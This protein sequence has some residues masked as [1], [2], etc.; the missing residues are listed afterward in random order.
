MSTKKRKLGFAIGSAF[1]ALGSL[2]TVLFCTSWYLM[3][4]FHETF[5]YQKYNVK[6]ISI[7]L[8]SST[9]GESDQAVQVELVSSQHSPVVITAHTRCGLGEVGK[10]LTLL[11]NENS[12]KVLGFQEELLD[13]MTL[14]LFG[15]KI[16]FGILG[17]LVF[18]FLTF[19]FGSAEHDKRST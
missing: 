14:M 18:G 16:I 2:L 8:C 15:Y 10:S 5:G 3:M 7:G 1:I 17:S 13:W 9:K 4:I 12:K 19:Y 11:M 6:I